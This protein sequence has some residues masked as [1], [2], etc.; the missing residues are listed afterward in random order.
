MFSL[1]QLVACATFLACTQTAN[2]SLIVN[3]G[4][5]D[6]DIDTLPANTP[7]LGKG[8]YYGRPGNIFLGLPGGSSIP[9]WTTSGTRADLINNNIGTAPVS[10]ATWPI[11]HGGEQYMYLNAW[12]N[13]STSMYQQLAL[14]GGNSYSL[15]FFL[16]GLTGYGNFDG[17]PYQPQVIVSLLD[18]S[19]ASVYQ[20]YVTG[21]SNTSWTEIDLNFSVLNSGNYRLVF[22]TPTHP[23]LPEGQD[24]N[25]IALDD[26]S[27]FETLPPPP[28]QPEEPKP[29]SLPPTLW[30]VAM[31]LVGVGLARRRYN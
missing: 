26:I 17:L 16:N 2:A 24:Q 27:L 31:G 8:I 13:T 21:T 19:L 12:G 15:E 30:F 9:G 25:F 29:I 1:K 23:V 7:Y 5:E 22:S 3:G 28:P 20:T 11:A 14:T 6:L 4:F 10:G 18:D